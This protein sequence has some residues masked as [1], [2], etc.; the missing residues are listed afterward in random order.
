[1]RKLLSLLPLALLSLLVTC[2]N[3]P[4]P[5]AGKPDPDLAT[6]TAVPGVENFCKITDGV[7]RGAQ[8][9]A[10]GFAELKRLGVKTVVNLRALHSDRDELK[11]LGLNYVHLPMTA[12][13]PDDDVVA[14]FIKV[15]TDPHFRPVFV[16]C[17][18]GADRT[19][20]VIAAY[21]VTVQGW[22]MKKARRELP[23]FGFHEVFVSLEAYLDRF[24]AE[25]IARKIPRV[26]VKVEMVP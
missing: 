14:A 2:V 4:D 5:D 20:V 21:R 18:H 6:P 22:P 13:I 3:P 16:H 15:A 23:L 9:T 7:W 10:E 17:Q 25:E 24:D 26:E 1:M 19:G 11:G 12:L 8:P